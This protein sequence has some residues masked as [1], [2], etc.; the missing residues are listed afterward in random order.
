M[1]HFVVAN[2]FGPN[3]NHTGIYVVLSLRVVICNQNPLQIWMSRIIHAK[4]CVVRL[5][6]KNMANLKI[7]YCPQLQSVDPGIIGM[8]LCISVNRNNLCYE[9]IQISISA[10]RREHYTQHGWL[11]LGKGGS[12]LKLA[13]VMNSRDVH[14]TYSEQAHESRNFH[15]DGFRD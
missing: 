15:V 1:L 10:A 13:L 14:S 3:L 8:I 11:G 12:R 6:A 9:V 7:R 4:I 5:R 2:L